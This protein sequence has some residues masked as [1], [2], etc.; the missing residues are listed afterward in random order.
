MLT[1]THT[2]TE[3]DQELVRAD[4]NRRI[5]E[6]FITKP[7]AEA[8]SKARW[9]FRLLCAAAGLGCLIIAPFQSDKSDRNV[10]LAAGLLCVCPWVFS[11]IGQLFARVV[12]FAFWIKF[13]QVTKRERPI[14]KTATWE[15]TDEDIIVNGKGRYPWAT[16][17]SFEW[18]E[19]GM[20]MLDKS[21]IPPLY[22]PAD[23]LV[24]P[25]IRTKLQEILDRRF[26]PPVITS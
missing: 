11:N 6:D 10:L 22:I 15:F 21:K 3:K 5:R 1:I 9:P 8:R 13:R 12:M 7:C 2:I 16:F 18:V 4:I 19:A 23:A 26:S 20:V 25:V 14:G 24:D 17:R